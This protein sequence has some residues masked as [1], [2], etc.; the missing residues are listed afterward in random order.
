MKR[1]KPRVGKSYF[2]INS[3]FEIKYTVHTGSE[4]SRK[5]I[6][7]GNCF[8]TREQARAFRAMIDDVLSG[9]PIPTAKPWWRFW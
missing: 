9:V 2:M 3:R 5:R 6:E 8:K 4:K 7:A 1:Y